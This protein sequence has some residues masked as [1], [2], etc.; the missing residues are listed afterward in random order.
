[1]AIPFELKR[2]KIIGNIATLFSGS[3]VAQGMTAITLL[4]TARQLQVDGYGQYAAC[5]TLI[6]MLSILFSLGLDNWLLREGGR[7]PHQ[8]GNIAGSV[9]GIKGIF[10]PVWVIIL[11]LLSPILNQQSFPSTLLR[12][13]VIFIWSDTLLA[14]CLS[15][16]KSMLHNKVPSIIEAGADIIWFGFTI[17]LMWFGLNQPEAFMKIRAFVSLLALSISLLFLASRFNL[18]F[19]LHIAREALASA[20]PFAASDFLA[21]IIMRA[22]IVIIS[23]TI[24]KTATGLYSPAVGLVNMAFLVP[25]AIYMVMLPVLSNLYKNHPEQAQKTASRT[26]LLSLFVGIVLTFAYFI[27]APLIT[28]LLGSSYQGSIEV[29][30]ILSWVL[31]FRCG[32]FAFTAIIV[33]TN[34]QAKRTFIQVIAAITNI[35]LNLLVV[36]KYGING[37]AFVYVLTEIITFFGYSWVI[38]RK[39]LANEY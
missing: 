24:G 39:K 31:I 10:G 2:S 20:F 6:S 17:L 1:M 16:F 35:V 26:I 11:L 19:H 38:W 15:V 22:D 5:I 8:A 33:A 29:L 27:G 7:A 25:M 18:H 12:W 23:L 37:V 34:Q 36:Y 30:K 21:M 3:V 9:L 4:L 14:T 32:S 28:T 13:S